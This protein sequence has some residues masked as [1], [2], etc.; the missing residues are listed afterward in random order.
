MSETDTIIAGKIRRDFCRHDDIVDG[1]TVLGV[2]ERDFS[3]LGTKQLELF[4]GL[5][6]FSFYSLFDSIDE[7][8]FRDSDFDSFEIFPIPD[9]WINRDRFIETR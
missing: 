9:G 2:R 1:E 7:V 6:D 8:F 5:I 4:Y 3:N